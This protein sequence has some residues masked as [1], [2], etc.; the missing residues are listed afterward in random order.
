MKY[1]LNELLLPLRQSVAGCRMQLCDCVYS[2]AMMY[3]PGVS[4]AEDKKELEELS[5]EHA[6]KLAQKVADALK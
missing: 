3:V 1:E 5:T 6:K 4:T 2:T